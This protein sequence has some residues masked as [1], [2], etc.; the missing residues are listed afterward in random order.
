M[1]LRTGVPLSPPRAEALAVAPTTV[2]MADQDARALAQHRGARPRV[3]RGALRD[4]ASRRH[5]GHPV[6]RE[7]RDRGGAHDDGQGRPALHR[8][9]LCRHVGHQPSP[10]HRVPRSCRR[11]ALLRHR[12]R[13][14]PVGADRRDPRPLRL[15]GRGAHARHRG[16]DGGVV[17]D[18][19]TKNASKPANIATAP[20]T[21][22]SIPISSRSASPTTGNDS[23][24]RA[25]RSMS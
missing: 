13:R 8:Q 4:H 14:H 3:S 18:A 22:G 15:V 20:R 5:Q 1:R 10:V 24:S 6:G 23:R 11:G 19:T 12:V 2:T 16:R 9:A 17:E 25:N 21:S 7:R